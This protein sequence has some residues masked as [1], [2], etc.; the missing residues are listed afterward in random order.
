MKQNQRFRRPSGGAK[1]HG[2][3]RR[4][5]KNEGSARRAPEQ[6]FELSKFRMGITEEEYFDV[7]KGGLFRHRSIR[8]NEQGLK[9]VL[10]LLAKDT[11]GSG[12]SQCL[13]FQFS[14]TAEE[15]WNSRFNALSR[16]LDFHNH[17]PE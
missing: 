7:A 9:L 4:R 6:S 2:R 10:D 14:G 1:R 5:V 3:G 16:I 17:T 15:V 8:A 11:D 13:Y 12:L